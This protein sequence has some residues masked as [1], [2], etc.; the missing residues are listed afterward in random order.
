[1]AKLDPDDG[2]CWYC[3]TDDGQLAFCWEFDT[4]VHPECAANAY[5]CERLLGKEI[6]T[7]TR[8]IYEEVCGG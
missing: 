4:W 8:L 6:N 2:G 1:M 7:E 5:E 3:Y